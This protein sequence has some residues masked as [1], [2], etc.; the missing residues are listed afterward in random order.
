M[1]TIT[2][3]EYVEIGGIPLATPAWEVTNLFVLWEGPDTRGA[4]RIVPGVDGVKPYR[5]RAT[6]S[7]RTLEM[8]IYGTHDEDGGAYSDV[9]AGLAANV[10]YLRA[11][12]F[13]P[14]D[15]GDGTRT[16]VLHLP[17][18][19]TKSGLVHV[20]AALFA[21]AGPTSL[22]AAVDL[23]LVTGSLA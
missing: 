5:R 8:V 10:E 15:V 20:E 2:Y 3:T 7:K 4:D 16:A 23:T 22:R 13:D 19:A 17:S 1:P 14:T 21:S 12:V 6:V 18:G 11:N 9:R